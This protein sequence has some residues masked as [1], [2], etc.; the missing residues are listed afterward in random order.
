MTLRDMPISSRLNTS[1]PENID[2]PRLSCHIAHRA[3]LRD[4]CHEERHSKFHHRLVGRLTPLEW[5]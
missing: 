2:F 5:T 4:K 1:P 3:T